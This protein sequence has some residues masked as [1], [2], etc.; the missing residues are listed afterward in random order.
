MEQKTG[1]SI[2]KFA[3]MTTLSEEEIEELQENGELAETISESADI[4]VETVQEEAKRE[5]KGKTVEYDSVPRWQ[6]MFWYSMRA[7]YFN[8]MGI[9]GVLLG[10][11]GIVLFFTGYGAE[12]KARWIMF[13]PFILFCVLNPGTLLFR[14]ISFYSKEENRACTHYILSESFIEITRDELN[15]ALDWNEVKQIDDCG[16]FLGVQFKQGQ[17]FVAPKSDLG[18]S[19]DAFKELCKEKAEKACR[20]K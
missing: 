18:E 7:T 6:D 19:V 8:V 10:I 9:V 17:T 11:A 20:F 3:R 5:H 16:S 2:S 14:Y 12:A 15:V 1:S 13:L 4:E